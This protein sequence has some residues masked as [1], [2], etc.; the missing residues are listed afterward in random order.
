MSQALV[1]V[2]VR[3]CAFS[4]CFL[5]RQRKYGGICVSHWYLTS[6]VL[7]ITLPPLRAARPARRTGRPL[8]G[9]GAGGGTERKEEEEREG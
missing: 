7:V 9:G 1:Y 6:G 8:R 5:V 4:P 2:A 3:S